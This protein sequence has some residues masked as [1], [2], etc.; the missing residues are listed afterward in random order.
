[1]SIEPFF[2]KRSSLHVVFVKCL[3][4]TY[5]REEFQ[6]TQLK[7]PFFW[8]S[9][10]QSKNKIMFRTLI[11][12]YP[13]LPNF[14]VLFFNRK[15][16]KEKI[17]FVRVSKTNHD[18]YKI[19]HFF[20]DSLLFSILFHHFSEKRLLQ[21]VAYFSSSS[22]GIDHWWLVVIVVVQHLLTYIRFN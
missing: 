12:L 7:M 3:K 22:F 5:N 21:H 11:F 4:L 20:T 15:L 6:V 19:N 9:K 10:A 8:H 16:K 1:M 13:C 2:K 17:T 14:L 18:E